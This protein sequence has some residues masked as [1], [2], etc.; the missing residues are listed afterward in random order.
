MRHLSP[1]EQHQI[2]VTTNYDNL[3]GYRRHMINE[4]FKPLDLYYNEQTARFDSQDVDLVDKAE[5]YMEEAITGKFAKKM[6]R[7]DTSIEIQKLMKF[8]DWAIKRGG[9]AFNQIKRKPLEL[10]TEEEKEMQK[11][12]WTRTYYTGRQQFRF[13]RKFIND[14][15]QRVD[16]HVKDNAQAYHDYKRRA[17]FP[18]ISDKSQAF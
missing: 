6:A 16:V 9:D 17:L 5:R 4:Q 3:M 14:Y 10:C 1:S 11:P 12:F 13:D 18:K 8:V 2:T 15:M 7:Y